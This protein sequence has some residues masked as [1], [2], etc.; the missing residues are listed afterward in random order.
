MHRNRTCTN[1]APK[2]GGKNCSR[3]GP[4]FETK[5]CNTLPCPLHGG[6]SDWSNFSE[7]SASCNNGI[8]TRIRTCSNPLPQHGGRNCSHVGPS[9]ETT[10]CFLKVCPVDG[11]YSNWSEFGECDKSCSGGLKKRK[12]KCNNP[13]PVGDG[14][15]C[16]VLGPSVDWR[17]CNS[18]PCPVNG[19]YTAWSKF[20]PCM[21]SCGVGAQFR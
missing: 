11:N 12:R 9:S 15:N 10:S 7:C 1:P 21:K 4:S 6:Y 19:N 2:F 17:S 5:H 14:N 20:S 13:T 8:K 18:Q 3:L 16:S